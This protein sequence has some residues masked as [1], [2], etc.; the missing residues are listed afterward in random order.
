MMSCVTAVV[1]IPPTIMMPFYRST[2]H[3]A[4]CDVGTVSLIYLVAML[5]DICICNYAVTRASYKRM[6]VA[7]VSAIMA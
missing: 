6:N 3:L 2:V 7:S 4:Y 1:A 5:R